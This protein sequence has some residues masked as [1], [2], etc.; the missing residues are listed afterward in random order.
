MAGETLPD[1]DLL[2]AMEPEELAAA[3]LLSL[4]HECLRNS[5]RMVHR[6]NFLSSILTA[7]NYSRSRFP[8]ERSSEV[9]R[10]VTEAWMW[11]EGQ[12]LLVPAGT[13]NGPAGWR[14][15]SRRAERIE[16]ERD[17]AQFV[18][19]RFLRKDT[20]H[21]AIADLVW[22]AFLRGEYDVA[23][24]QAMKA[25]EIAVRKA[26]GFPDASLGVDLMRKAFNPEN[27]PL[28]NSAAPYPEREAL[29]SLFAGAIGTYKNPQSH[30]EVGVED[31]AQAAEVVLIANQLLRIVDERAAARM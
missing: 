29:S 14:T 23:V 12:G 24:F 30:R 28:T 18:A 15:L 22:S 10:A 11:L 31:P 6:T 27:G 26:G 7:D 20:L 1:I 25:V 19:S 13:A 3:L 4:R 21:K 16:D 17:F 2:L 9:E 5:Q 8:A